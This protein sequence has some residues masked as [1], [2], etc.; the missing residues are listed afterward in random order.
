MNRICF[1]IKPHAAEDAKAII[2]TLLQTSDDKVR[3]NRVR[4]QRWNRAIA[5]KF[6]EEHDGQSFYPRLIC[7]MCGPVVG[8]V[9]EVASIESFRNMMVGATDPKAA[10]PG[11]LRARFGV[12]MPFN[13][14]HASDSVEAGTREIALMLEAEGDGYVMSP[15]G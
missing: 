2:E 8:I 6:Y 1:L 11:T 10:E 9:L 15:R 13:A 3:I 7:S 12:E 14:V 4:F 5:S